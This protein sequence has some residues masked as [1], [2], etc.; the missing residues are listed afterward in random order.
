[1]V[2]STFSKEPVMRANCLSRRQFH[3]MA[4]TALGAPFVS[5]SFAEE[6]T[7]P[8]SERITLGFIG[9][10]K[11]SR[12]LL[13]HM[14]ASDQVQVLAIAEVVKERREHGRET[15]EKHYG[16]TAKGGMYRGC[17]AYVDFRDIVGRRDID[18]VVIGTPDHWHAIQAVQAA[19][20]GK[21]IY[22]EKPL[23]LTISEGR[24]MVEAARRYRIVFQTGSQQRSEYGGKFRHAVELVRNGRI[25][26]VKTIRVGVGGPP[27]PC[28]LPEQPTPDGTDWEMWNGP[29]PA[30]GYH[31]VLC[32][33]GVHNHFPA[34]R[35]Y[36]EYAGG[37]LA[38][39]GAHH[40]DIAQWALAMD[41]SGPVRVE[42]PADGAKTGLKFTYANGVEMYHGG[43]SGCTF[44]GTAGKIYVDR[45]TLKSEPVETASQTISDDDQRVYHSTGHFADW[46][47]CMRSRQHPI[48]D[49]EVGHRSA[50]IC[51]LANI[52]YELGRTLA[53]DPAGERFVNDEEANRLLERAPR[54]PWTL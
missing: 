49:V 21:D 33:R 8:P 39:M 23:T 20:A 24:K 11:R 14:M 52:G 16:S 3:L 10:G 44:E 35:R 43:L 19:R 46:L 53:W 41:R 7:L 31:E 28:D 13:R 27:V 34:F 38:D 6:T 30:R 15:V 18:A 54:A 17:A 45:G 37:G 2:S 48:C 22:C 25:G 42:P 1:M 29:A 5:R 4:A 51:H 50:T 32:P 40:F 36:R 47:A 12:S 26:T 9:M